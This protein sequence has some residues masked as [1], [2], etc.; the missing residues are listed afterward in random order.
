MEY[1]IELIEKRAVPTLHIRKSLSVDDLQVEIGNAFNRIIEYL[2]DLGVDKDRIGLAYVAY[3]H[4]EMSN[5]KVEIGYIVADEHPN[6]E[7]IHFGSI[8]GGRWVS[9][10]HKGSYST[11]GCGYSV[12]HKYLSKEELHPTGITYEYYLNTIDDVSEDQLLTKVELQI[13]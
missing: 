8:E 10:I 5:L 1:V 4:R 9:F 2:H 3:L 11:L 12:A 13:S 7:D 6:M